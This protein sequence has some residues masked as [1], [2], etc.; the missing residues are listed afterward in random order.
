M[1]V[2]LNGNTFLFA[3]PTREYSL[4]WRTRL[5]RTEGKEGKEKEKEGGG[6]VRSGARGSP[7]ARGPS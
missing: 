2:E 4:A 7:A 6:P 5:S 3:C 1:N